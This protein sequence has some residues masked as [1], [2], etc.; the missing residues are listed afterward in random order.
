MLIKLPYFF[1]FSLILLCCGGSPSDTKPS[2][3]PIVQLTSNV[4][5][6][7]PQ[8]NV[9][10]NSTENESS[11]NSDS[12]SDVTQNTKQF[13]VFDSSNNNDDTQVYDIVTNT[14]KVF[15]EDL[16][17]DYARSTPEH[18]LI[19][20]GLKWILNVTYEG[21]FRVKAGGDSD[22]S[23]SVG[24][25]AYNIHNDSIFLAGHAHHKAVAEFKIPNTLSTS[26]EIIN[27]PFAPVLQDFT[28]VLDKRTNGRMTNKITGMLY[29]QGALIINSEIAYDAGANN[30]DNTQV[31]YD[32][33]S[34]RTSPYAGLFQIE[35]GA[36]A[37]GYMSVV[38]QEMQER[39]GGQYIVGWASN[40]SINGR[41][42]IGPSLHTFN[43]DDILNADTE[44]NYS[45]PVD[46]YMMFPLQ[47]PIVANANSAHLDVS[48]IW[49]ETS[50]AIYAFII[51]DT[52][53]YLVIGS[54]SGLHSG[55]G[56]K[57]TQD[58]GRIC[59]GS[60]PYEASDY[61]NYFWLFD[62]NDILSAENPHSILP[63]S[64]GKWSH[65]FDDDGQHKV[66]GATFDHYNHRLFIALNAAGQVGRY[67]SVPLIISY[68]ISARL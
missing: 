41:Y 31:F 8:T 16:V 13:D 19:P 30:K 39:L 42:S 10:E 46:T 65:P 55:L 68:K 67:D 37:A 45:I 50:R 15:P 21:Y 56:Y 26:S 3:E 40:Y 58:S 61:Y 33:S 2:Q 54:H 20:R 63:V 18:I 9:G 62:V 7:T 44:I 6:Q 32:A 52:N 43:P 4:S 57:I 11:T 48:P 60:C 14:A 23:H 36:K 17:R 22:A 12:N 64:Y 25:L 49:A 28:S 5:N 51:P 27:E 38:P 29:N 24:T 47:N 35:H 66:I 34:L 1:I 53:Y 59:G